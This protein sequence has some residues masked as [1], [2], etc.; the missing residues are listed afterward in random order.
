M[1]PWF[2]STGVLAWLMV[3]PGTMILD[4]SVGVNNPNLVVPVLTFSALGLL[5]LTILA[6][7]VRDAQPTRESR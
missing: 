6:G 1:W 5:L 2:F 7:F 4:Q 3:M